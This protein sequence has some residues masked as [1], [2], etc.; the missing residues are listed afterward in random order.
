MIELIASLVI[1]L[2]DQHLI[3]CY[4]NLD[5]QPM[6]SADHLVGA[7]HPVGILVVA[8]NHGDVTRQSI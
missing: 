7:R 5:T 3:T 1:D 6:G 4:Q 8:K 2:S